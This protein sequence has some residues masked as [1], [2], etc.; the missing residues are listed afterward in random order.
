MPVPLRAPAGVG[1]GAAPIGSREWA[2]YVRLHSHAVVDDAIARP[3]QFKKIHDFI[4]TH[5]AWTLM[6]KPDG[7]FFTTIEEFS[8]HRRP[9]G[10]GRP[11]SGLR[12][13]LA[14]A[15]G[16]LSIET[17]AG[18]VAADG[19][20][21]LALATAPVDGR[22]GNGANQHT[23]PASEALAGGSPA[24]AGAAT[25]IGEDS[26]PK[27]ENPRPGGSA[28]RIQ[29]ILRAP[30]E[31]QALFKAGLIGEKV[32]ARLGPKGTAKAPITPDKAAQ[33]REAVNAAEAVV[34]ENGAPKDD[35]A[36]RVLKQKVD[37][38][39]RR[40]LGDE[41]TSRRGVDVRRAVLAFAPEDRLRFA[42][43]LV[44]QLGAEERVQLADRLASRGSGAGAP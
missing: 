4:V 20:K 10:W 30:A 42:L 28:Q 19:A 15:A 38:E 33:V 39:V 23:R 35:R 25:P 2:D 16:T 12:P 5:R 22:H 43:W 29:A 40:V 11:Y 18:P 8:A 13:F 21:A 14:A 44:D 1:K 27:G 6:N 26:H 9:W 34:R 3:A 31:A 36:K 17:P 41:P 37:A 7:S 24:A 32:A